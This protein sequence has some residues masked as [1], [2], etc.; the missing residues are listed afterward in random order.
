MNSELCVRTVV[1]NRKCQIV[2]IFFFLIEFKMFFKI[3]S[4]YAQIIYTGSGSGTPKI[5]SWIG[6][7]SF[8]IHN[9][10]VKGRSR[11]PMATWLTRMRVSFL[12]PSQVAGYLTDE[13]ESELLVSQVA[14]VHQWGP[15]APVGPVILITREVLHVLE[16]LKKL[17]IFILLYSKAILNKNNSYMLFSRLITR[18][19]VFCL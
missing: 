5:R 12:C 8:R 13:E 15:A 10:G 17:E 1:W 7:K 11:W 6:N 9:A 2:S 14:G 19:C 4:K 16:R 18:V 3:I